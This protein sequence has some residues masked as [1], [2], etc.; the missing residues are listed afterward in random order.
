[1]EAGHRTAEKVC[2]GGESTASSGGRVVSCLPSQRSPRRYAAENALS[3]QHKILTE[4]SFQKRRR[5]QGC[6]LGHLL[7][8]QF[9]VGVR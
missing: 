1:M 4:R 6:T 9:L 5:K 7:D 3:L 8:P 2:S